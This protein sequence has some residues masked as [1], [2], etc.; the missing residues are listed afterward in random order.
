M[1]ALSGCSPKCGSATTKGGRAVHFTG[2]G[3]VFIPGTGLEQ[4]SQGV[5]RMETRGLSDPGPAHPQAQ[6]QSGRKDASMTS[7]VVLQLGLE[8]SGLG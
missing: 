7:V 4:V 6:K 1:W 3:H 8:I 5:G 2:T